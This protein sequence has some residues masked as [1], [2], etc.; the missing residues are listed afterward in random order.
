MAGR[1]LLEI[2]EEAYKKGTETSSPNIH[3]DR[4][5]DPSNANGVLDR[6]DNDTQSNNIRQDLA[7]GSEDRRAGVIPATNPPQLDSATVNRKATVASPAESP[8]TTK[9]RNGA[10]KSVSQ[11]Q[12]PSA[13]SVSISDLNPP[14]DI[15]SSMKALFE[16]IV[17]TA[18]EQTRYESLKH[19]ERQQRDEQTRWSAYYDNF[20]SLGEDQ[21]RNLEA[22]QSTKGR[23]EK[24][25]NQARQQ[26]EQAVQRI[27][28]CLSAASAAR[29]APATENNGL[30]KRLE[31]KVLVQ[32]EEIEFLKKEI[33]ALKRSA[34]EAKSNHHQVEEV[35]DT[36]RRQ[37][38]E[39]L[40][41]QK[42]T[43]RK[44]THRENEAKYE[45]KISELVAQSKVFTDFTSKQDQINRDLSRFQ[46]SQVA[47]KLEAKSELQE[48]KDGFNKN[49]SNYRATRATLKTVEDDLVTSK[50]DTVAL[51]EFKTR[52]EETAHD[53]E[54]RLQ[55]VNDIQST[56]KSCLEQLNKRFTN[57]VSEMTKYAHATRQKTQEI[58]ETYS[59]DHRRL[60]DELK[61]LKVQLS[62]MEQ[63]LDDKART[64]SDLASYIGDS[65]QLRD[66]QQAQ[67]LRL[68]SVMDAFEKDGQARSGAIDAQSGGA[69]TITRQDFDKLWEQ[70]NAMKDFGDQ[71]DEAVGTDLDGFNNTL[72]EATKDFKDQ[73]V[74]LADYQSRLDKQED[75]LV[76]LCTD[77]SSTTESLTDVKA[78]MVEIK[79]E[80]VALKDSNH[81]VREE[82][83]AQQ[84]VIHQLQPEISELRRQIDLRMQKPTQPSPPPPVCGMKD[85]VQP[86][87]EALETFIQDLQNSKA[88]L[89]D[90]VRAIETFQA[91]YE[92]RWN[93]LTT[94]SMVN[95]VLFHLQRPLRML[96][97]D[98]NQVKQQ[99]HQSEG[100]LLPLSDL[101]NKNHDGV[102]Q[103]LGRI[104]K[105]ARE[106]KEWSNTAVRA[107][108]ATERQIGSI[109]ES[110]Q[111]HG[112]QLEKI[113]LL[114]N[115]DT[116]TKAS[117]AVPEIKD[118]V[119]KL[120]ANYD[121]AKAAMREIKEEHASDQARFNTA[122]AEN[123][124]VREMLLQAYRRQAQDPMID[125]IQE[126][127]KE[128]ASLK[129][130]CDDAI[131]THCKKFKTYD[132][133]IA[134]KSEMVEKLY[135]I[136]TTHDTTMAAKEGIDRKLD[137]FL[138]NHNAVMAA[139]SEMNEKLDS[140]QTM[141]NATTAATQVVDGKLTDFLTKYNAMAAASGEKLDSAQTSPDVPNPAIQN[142]NRSFQKMQT[143]MN[144]EVLSLR[145]QLAKSEEKVNTVQEILAEIRRRYE[146]VEA[147]DTSNDHDSQR[148][149][150]EA[151]PGVSTLQ[152]P[153]SDSDPPVV[154][155][156]KRSRRQRVDPVQKK[157]KMNPYPIGS[158]DESY[159]G[160]RST[161]RSARSKRRSYNPNGG[162]E[163]A[164][165]ETDST[166][167]APHTAKGL[168]SNLSQPQLDKPSPRKGRPPKKTAPAD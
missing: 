76:R 73:K 125:T 153:G 104:E 89:T 21:T 106:A 154:R 151:H 19:D 47:T 127:K 69:Q 156:G 130:H 74:I 17:T 42:N 82:N 67:K 136:Q 94:E 26:G 15:Q 167:K 28:Q 1:T 13:T 150:A 20:V 164:Y 39:L 91:T 66:E 99:Q 31:R 33:S 134:A 7:K 16:S 120:K 36:Q 146:K 116:S 131:A 111:R 112:A 165:V 96:Q 12:T 161:P 95:G 3:S 37:E 114:R 51:Q 121:V 143:S 166:S 93:N 54:G 163:D 137:E 157:R 83:D 10:G 6:K 18:V 22:T 58:T 141:Y 109:Q 60:Y 72:I 14:A 97:N 25:L 53:L 81:T 133:S 144:G 63:M 34:V 45:K 43:V 107:V 129:A 149:V 88:G 138:A 87:I 48:L 118:E 41:L 55:Q 122:I 64:Q 50:Q 160:E 2:K 62:S 4:V 113:E 49:N 70:L 46:A 11:P 23:S 29:P 44:S 56:E 86:K 101:V 85:E 139:K 24:Q 103:D 32:T 61:A 77:Q 162:N 110:L 52:I 128:L 168:S 123:E 8:V 159:T 148:E 98:I 126:I 68:D 147:M 124:R 27:V 119:G 115:N 59:T 5:R 65:Q 158:D 140:V 135:S 108:Q 105:V 92:S 117:S 102:T 38:Q 84:S 30:A 90:K 71:I 75:R 78:E 155:S 80:I 35:A 142:L 132:L 100:Q 9:I 152:D 145:A 40:E 79:S 57:D